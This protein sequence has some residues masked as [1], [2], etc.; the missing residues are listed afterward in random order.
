MTNTNRILEIAGIFD[1]ALFLA[2]CKECQT[3]GVRSKYTPLK[4]NW[5]SFTDEDYKTASIG[6]RM[7]EKSKLIA[8]TAD[9]KQAEALSILGTKTISRMIK[10]FPHPSKLVTKRFD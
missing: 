7:L 6:V 3:K 1:L 8:A 5:F 2:H 9:R 4:A 10:D